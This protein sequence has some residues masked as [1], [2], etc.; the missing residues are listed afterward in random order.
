VIGE[1]IMSKKSKAM[2][3]AKVA[4]GQAKESV[5]QH[6]GNE[7]LASKGALEQVEGHLKQAEGHLKQAGEKVKDVFNK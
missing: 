2:N 4:Q 7:E 3:A 1:Q 6:L 5:G